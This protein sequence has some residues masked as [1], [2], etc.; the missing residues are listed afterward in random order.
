VPVH[1][2]LW[3]PVKSS[4]IPDDLSHCLPLS[5][6]HYIQ[7]LLKLVPSSFTWPSSFPRSSQ[8]SCCNLF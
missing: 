3:L 2:E 8:C 7:A 5:Y 4:S 6:S 1:S